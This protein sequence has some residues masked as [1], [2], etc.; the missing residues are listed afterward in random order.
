MFHFFN[1]YNFEEK[2]I[3]THDLIRSS[4]DNVISVLERS[5]ELKSSDL[6]VV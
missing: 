6:L 3:L 4:V 1:S 2:S 5:E